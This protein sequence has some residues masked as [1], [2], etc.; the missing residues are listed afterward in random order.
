[1]D[2]GIRFELETR[3]KAGI[4]AFVPGRSQICYGLWTKHSPSPLD[5]VS[6]LIPGSKDQ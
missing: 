4:R 2:S 5:P 1:M 6:Q 3:L